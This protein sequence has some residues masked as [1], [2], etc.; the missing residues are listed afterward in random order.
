MQ[1]P[2]S[3][4]SSSAVR[5][6]RPRVRIPARL[7][8]SFAGSSSAP[9]RRARNVQ[10]TAAWRGAAHLLPRPP[11]AP[12]LLDQFNP[13]RQ[14]VQERAIVRH[15]SSGAPGETGSLSLSPLIRCLLLQGPWPNLQDLR[16]YLLYASSV[17]NSPLV[18]CAI[19]VHQ[20]HLPACSLP[21]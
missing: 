21:E 12:P 2:G 6:P 4:G 3:P 9:G 10:A 19:A 11:Q 1:G 13:D 15:P 7:A 8:H 16:C 17:W 18:F 14:M 20:I 5:F